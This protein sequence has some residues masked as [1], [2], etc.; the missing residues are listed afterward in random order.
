[1]KKVQIKI[2]MGSSCFSRGNNRNVEIIE[3][4]V[5]ENNLSAK[6]DLVGSLCINKCSKGPVIIINGKEYFRVTPD[7]IPDLLKFHFK[8]KKYAK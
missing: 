1:M 4:F 2:C 8:E 5:Q 3:K 6:V 7:I